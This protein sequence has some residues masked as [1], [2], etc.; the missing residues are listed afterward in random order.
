[1]QNKSYQNYDNLSIIFSALSNPTRRKILYYLQPGEL[2]VKD[3]SKPFEISIPA[4]IK[5]LKILEKAGLITRKRKAQTNFCKL[6]TD[7][8]KDV[9][10]WLDEY[11][12]F[13]DTS[14]KRIDLYI[15]KIKMEGSNDDKN[16]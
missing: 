12:K 9:S 16:S 13:W 15:D 1:M 5:H 7:P 10:K 4:I 2:S 11:K 14:F 3:L 6:N 8:L